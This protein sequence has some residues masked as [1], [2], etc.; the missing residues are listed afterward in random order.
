MKMKLPFFIVLL[1]LSLLSSAQIPEQDQKF[2]ARLKTELNLSADKY[3]S[4][5]KIYSDKQKELDACDKSIKEFEQT[6]DN[7]QEL[8]M[9]VSSLNQKK[10]DIREMRELD[11]KL[12][13]TPDQL[14]IY[15]E[16]IKPAKPQVL[17]FGIHDRANCK[18][19]VQ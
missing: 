13:L 9:K 5:E 18:V 19:C 1:C 7:E 15:D 11:I 6:L 8:Q 12:Q 2:L 3:T 16:K 14:K 17:H 10:K 4:I